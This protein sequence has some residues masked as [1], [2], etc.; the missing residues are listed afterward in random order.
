MDAAG[1]PLGKMLLTTVNENHGM[2]QVSAL[3]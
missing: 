3:H 1:V 2:L